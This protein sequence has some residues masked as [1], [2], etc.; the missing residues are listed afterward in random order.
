MKNR[1]LKNNKK[2]INNNNKKTKYCIIGARNPVKNMLVA[3]GNTPLLNWLHLYDAL[4]L[5]LLAIFAAQSDSS[6][7]RRKLAVA[8]N[9]LIDVAGATHFSSRR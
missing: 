3:W 6:Q 2:I 9:A 1:W 7:S 4:T 8:D 5:L